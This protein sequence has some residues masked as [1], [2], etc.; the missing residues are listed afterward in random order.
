MASWNPRIPLGMGI[1]II[2][3]AG[4]GSRR[5]V[6]RAHL[7]IIGILLGPLD[8]SFGAVNPDSESVVMP[9]RDLGTPV[10]AFGAAVVFDQNGGVIIQGPSLYKGI[11]PR[12]QGPDLHPGQVGYHVFDMTA[13]IAHTVR[14]TSQCRI[15]SP[16]CLFL[17]ALFKRCGKP[18]LGI[19]GID[20]PDITQI[21][22]GDHF[23]E[24]FDHRIASIGVGH[25]KKHVFF[26]RE[27]GQFF[28]ISAVRG[29]RFVANHM[30]AV[31]QGQFC[32]G[33]MRTIRGY[34]DYKIDLIPTAPFGFHHLLERGVQSAFIKS[35]HLPRRKSVLIVLGK[36]TC[37]QCGLPV[38]GNGFPVHVT[39]KGALPSSDHSVSQDHK[40]T[41]L[42]IILRN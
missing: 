29:Q 39:D 38:Q 13:D 1:Q 18:F 28:S 5:F 42:S 7:S 20:E 17:P 8:R 14:N 23:P 41:S 15:G 2:P 22:L 40:L 27:P 37:S 33:K 19:L 30:D 36:T 31:F 12:T 35:E 11:Q 4:N 3:A 25:A 6:Q 16:G 24:V 32:D 26:G 34:D 10:Q 21:S 9:H